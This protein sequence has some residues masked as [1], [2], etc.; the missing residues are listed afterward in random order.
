MAA[1]DWLRGSGAALAAGA[2]GDRTR[3]C[4]PLP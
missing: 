2:A 1:A 4:E 3:G